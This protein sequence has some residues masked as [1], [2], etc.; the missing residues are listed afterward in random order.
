MNDQVF[1]QFAREVDGYLGEETL[2]HGFVTAD[3]R[4]PMIYRQFKLAANNRIESIDQNRYTARY[5][6][7]RQDFERAFPRLKCE[8]LV[9][10]PGNRQ[11]F[12][13]AVR[14]AD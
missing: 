1:R 12:L 13:S 2:V 3:L 9:L 14:I 8:S 11:E 7:S 6:K 10:F 4:A 5:P